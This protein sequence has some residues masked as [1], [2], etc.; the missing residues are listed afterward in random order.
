MFGFCL[1]G[2]FIL[3]YFYVFVVVHLFGFFFSNN[4]QS[5]SLQ[6][7]L[8]LTNHPELRSCRQVYSQAYL[9][10]L[11]SSVRYQKWWGKESF[12]EYKFKKY[13]NLQRFGS[14][15]DK[16]GSLFSFNEMCIDEDKTSPVFQVSVLKLCL[17]FVGATKN[18]AA[19]PLRQAGKDSNFLKKCKEDIND[20]NVHQNTHNSSW[21]W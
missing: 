2:F 17:K 13:S 18:R 9:M 19:P 15:V 12:F 16:N 21:F 8:F 11:I 6:V 20:W 1:W 5:T 14:L 4:I 7:R 10:A 3:F